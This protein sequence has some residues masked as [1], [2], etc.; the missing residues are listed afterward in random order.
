VAGH[1]TVPGRAALSIAALDDT[2]RIDM[3]RAFPG[4]IGTRTVD[5]L[6]T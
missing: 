5:V 6:V 1:T 3:K 4:P 2:W